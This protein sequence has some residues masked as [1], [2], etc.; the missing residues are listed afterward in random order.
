MNYGYLRC[1]DGLCNFAKFW[2]A[3]IEYN[4]AAAARQTKPMNPFI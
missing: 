3:I 1:H 2:F 4:L